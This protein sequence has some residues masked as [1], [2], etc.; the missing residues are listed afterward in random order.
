MNKE[1]TASLNKHFA[2]RLAVTQRSRKQRTM[3]GR[4]MC[5]SDNI[6]AFHFFTVI[7]LIFCYLR[8]PTD[9]K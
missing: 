6:H 2:E 5:V 1:L 8:L 9:R 7:M 3:R 4:S